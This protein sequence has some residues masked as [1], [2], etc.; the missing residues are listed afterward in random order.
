[1]VNY[2]VTKFRSIGTRADEQLAIEGTKLV[3]K[4]F[5]R[6]VKIADIANKYN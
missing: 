5:D 2:A 4:L 6:E 3:D 1:M